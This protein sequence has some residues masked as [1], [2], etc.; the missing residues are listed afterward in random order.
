MHLHQWA[1]FCTSGT[2]GT[3]GGL[4]GLP[5]EKKNVHVKIWRKNCQTVNEFIKFDHS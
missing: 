4:A 1:A 3:D 5:F 2:N